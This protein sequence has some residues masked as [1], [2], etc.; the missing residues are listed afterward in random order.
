MKT[1][2]FSMTISVILSS[3]H[4]APSRVQNNGNREGALPGSDGR[5]DKDS[6]DTTADGTLPSI[7][8][9]PSPGSAMRLLD[10]NALSVVYARIF[11]ARSYG[12]EICKGDEIKKFRSFGDCSS[13]IFAVE[14]RPFVGVT[15][16]NT[17]DLNR[18]TQN[19]R[20]PEDLTLNY[21]R[22]V[23][24]ALHRECQSRVDVEYQNLVEG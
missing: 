5:V 23:R 7:E 2:L 6:G 10:G 14:E 20:L 1:L 9:S 15:S 4:R 18:G 17:P 21:M 16:L 24:A 11:P 3:C 8:Y 22:T 19:I 13:S 12:F